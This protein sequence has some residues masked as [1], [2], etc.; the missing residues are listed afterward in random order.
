MNYELSAKSCGRAMLRTPKQV[1]F[2]L[3]MTLLLAVIPQAFADCN[4]GIRYIPLNEQQADIAQALQQFGRG[5]GKRVTGNTF[6]LGNQDRRYWL[7]VEVCNQTE[8]T[9]RYVIHT[10]VPFR[11][12]LQLY[13]LRPHHSRQMILDSSNTLPFYQRPLATRLLISEAFALAAGEQVALLADYQSQGASYLQ[14]LPMAEAQ[15]QQ[16]AA[17][18]AVLTAVF[19]SASV[20][21]LLVFVII[22]L[23]VREASVVSYA[24]LFAVALLFIA[25]QEGIGFQYL[26]P[27]WPQWNHWSSLVLMGALALAN[28]ACASLFVEANYLDRRVRPA[29]MGFMLLTLVLWLILIVC[30]LVFPLQWVAWLSFSLLAEIGSMLLLLSVLAQLLA[31]W[32]WSLRAGQSRLLTRPLL[33]FALLLLLTALLSLAAP[34]TLNHVYAYASRSV[35]TACVVAAMAALSAHILSI[36]K[37]Y[38]LS[39]TQALEAAQRDAALSHALAQAE[40]NY[41]RA[42]ALAQQHRMQLA[43]ASHDIRQPLVSMRALLAAAPNMDQRT[44]SNIEDALAYIE[45][46][47]RQYLRASHPHSRSERN[48]NLPI[49]QAN[50][51]PEPYQVNTLLH[52]IKRMFEAEASE[53]SVAFRVIDCSCTIAQPPLI[54]MRVL[55][56]LVSNALQHAGEGV[57]DSVA[58]NK[59]SKVLVGCRRGADTVQFQV[60][61]NGKGMSEL[62]VAQLFEPYAKGEHSTGEGLGLAICHSLAAEHGFGLAVQSQ[63]GRATCFSLTL[64]VDL[65]P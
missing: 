55:S 31:I 28:F 14:L 25:A 63:Q 24:A 52:S 47:S 16:Q 32:S 64:P 54:L 19:Y 37:A 20:V 29:I 30:L 7:Y 10:D 59:Q 65:L 26:W 33:V 23:V 12:M 9:Q 51:D 4:T 18:D 15:A 13:L 40:Q 49:P 21:V 57:A 48:A 46:L 41:S 11:P 1:L 45:A 27:S 2:L 8:D 39:L 38:Q 6:N 60:W 42:T 53:K 61:D 3:L 36:R 17:E 62:Q 56:N 22:G 5:A 44:A 50:A 35:F 34:E 43:T 58:D